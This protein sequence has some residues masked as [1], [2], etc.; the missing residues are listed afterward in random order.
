MSGARLI[1]LNGP[2]GIGKTTLA[3][4]YAAEHLGVLLCDIDVLRTMIGG[5]QDDD[6]AARGAALAPRRTR[7]VD[8]GVGDQRVDLD[9][10][11]HRRHQ[12]LTSMPSDSRRL[13]RSRDRASERSCETRDSPT[14]IT[15]PICW[16]STRR[17][18]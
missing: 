2:P 18:A 6:G 8:R 14:P 12:R 9:L 15:S 1:H 11:Q 7:A 10:R 13:A 3:R 5:W 16:A 17:P 4:R